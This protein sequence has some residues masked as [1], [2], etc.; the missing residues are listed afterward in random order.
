MAVSWTTGCHSTR[1]PERYLVDLSGKRPTSCG[2][3]QFLM[4]AVD[5][6]SRM[7]WPY[8]L[9][10]KSGVSATLDIFF[11]VANA[12]SVASTVE[13]VCSDNGTLFVREEFVELLDRRCIRC[14]LIPVGSPEHNGVV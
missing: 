14:V 5:H 2:E 3:V 8:F 7:G 4:M 1:P 13:Y 6:S 9:K 10:R 11:S 12:T